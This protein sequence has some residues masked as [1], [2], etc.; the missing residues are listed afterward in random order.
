MAIPGVVAQR[1]SKGP[2]G[3]RQRNKRAGNPKVTRPPNR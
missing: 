2:C 1:P 3:L